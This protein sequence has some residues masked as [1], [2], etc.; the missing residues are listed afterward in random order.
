MCFPSSSAIVEHPLARGSWA[1]KFPQI[2]WNCSNVW[3]CA[4]HIPGTVWVLLSWMFTAHPP[5]NDGFNDVLALAIGTWGQGVNFEVGQSGRRPMKQ[6]SHLRALWGIY[7]ERKVS[8]KP[9]KELQLAAET[10]AERLIQKCQKK[11]FQGKTY[12]NTWDLLWW[13]QKTHPPGMYLTDAAKNTFMKKD[14]E[15]SKFYCIRT[16]VTEKY[17]KK[18]L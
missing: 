13:E 16:T 8:Q 18:K 7:S 5:R 15:K 6:R 14:G 11:L 12:F 3:G 10:M 2:A 9:Q 1:T 4:A 17:F